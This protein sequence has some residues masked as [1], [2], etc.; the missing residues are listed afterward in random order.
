MIASVKRIIHSTKTHQGFRR[1][2]ANIS[3]MFVERILRLIA[4]LLVG[5]WVARYLGPTQ[6]GLFS[7]AVAFTAIFSNIAKLGLDSIVVRNLVIDPA[8]RDIYMGTAFWL[9]LT[10]A[11]VTLSLIAIAMQ[12]T[13]SDSTTKL[14]V[15]IIAGGAIFQ[16]FEVVDF[17]FQSQVL[18][19]FVSICKMTQLLI[20]SLLK[21]YLMSIE[22]DL[23]WFVLVSLVD[24]VTLAVSLFFAYRHQK[25]GR[26]FKSFDW[27]IAKKMLQDSWPLILSGLVI[28]I[29]MRIDQIM[30]K[31]MLGEREVGL[32]SAAVGLSEIWYFIPML[33]ASS[34]FPSIVNAK[35]ISEEKY[36]SRLQQLFT[37]LVW[38]SIA[39]AGLTT[40]LS[41]WLVVSLYGM[42]YQE[43]SQVLIIHTWGGVFVALG[44]ASG[45][46][47]VSENLQHYSFYRTASGAILNVML[48]FTLI[49]KYGISGAAIAT[50]ISQSMAALFFDLSTLKTRIIFIMKLKA[51]LFIGLYKK[52]Y[53]D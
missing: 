15:F 33:I 24:Q 29:Y 17:Y 18:S 21:L 48:N 31:E 36:L 44:V 52:K 20:S 9:K 32:Y 49:P 27:A 41:Q 47:F 10:G 45:S 53:N 6:Y 51:M 16:A 25:I 2:F 30:I 8:R 12:F 11:I 50:V 7:Y 35:K 43:A 42:A 38:I 4:G 40:L 14:Y 26:F 13:A 34:L 3:W 1:H 39:V 5:I 28:M 19:K 23:F 46:W 22:A 37:F